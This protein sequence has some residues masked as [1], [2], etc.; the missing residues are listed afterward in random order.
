MSDSRCLGNNKIVSQNSALQS[1]AGFVSDGDISHAI[2][3]RPRTRPAD[4][5]ILQFLLLKAEL[6]WSSLYR[7]VPL[8]SNPLM[9]QEIDMKSF[10]HRILN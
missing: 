5:T 7:L 3:A 6:A 2:P 1:P 9:T 8:H 10:E 4:P